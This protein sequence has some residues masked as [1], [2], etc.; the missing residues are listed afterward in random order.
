MKAANMA[1]VYVALYPELAGIARKH[2][3]ALAIHGSVA[4][5]FDLVF[6]PWAESVSTPDA[7][8]AELAAAYH[9]R[10]IGRLT[11]KPH[12]RLCQTISISF[13]E[14]FVDAS[15]VL[16]SVQRAPDGWALVPMEPT[17]AMLVAARLT[18]RDDIELTRD[19][20]A[21][22]YRAMISAGGTVP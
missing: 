15:F 6:V 18:E 2:G 1:P 7:V 9:F 21:D 17:E 4:R 10:L 14:C 20:W 19:E 12:G 11:E 3:Y 16:S 8:L 5:D 22:A 13:G